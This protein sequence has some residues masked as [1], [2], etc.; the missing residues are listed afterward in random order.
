VGYIEGFL[1]VNRDLWRLVEKQD[2]RLS[3]V[4]RELEYRRGWLTA[5]FRSGVYLANRIQEVYP[6]QGRLLSKYAPLG[7]HALMFHDE[8]LVQRAVNS[9]G[10]KATEIALAE[11]FGAKWEDLR[12][13]LL[14]TA[15]LFRR[16][17]HQLREELD[18]LSRICS[19]YNRLGAFIPH[20]GVLIAS[21]QSIEGSP[22][23][24]AF[25]K[26]VPWLLDVVYNV[27]TG[28]EA[29]G[30]IGVMG[31]PIGS[32]KTTTMYY[33]LRSIANIL[34]HP[35]PDRVASNLILLDPE[36]FL[37]AMDELAS[38]GEKALIT[39]VDN[40]STLFPKYWYTV[41]GEL[42]AFYL[43]LHKSIT[44]IRS[45]STAT[46]FIANAAGEI[47]SFIRNM[48]RV[49]ISG[50]QLSIP[51][52]NV[53]IFTMKEAGVRLTEKEDE[54]VKRERIASVYAY[55]LLKLPKHMYN[56]DLNLK[57]EINR[58]V[59]AEAVKIYKETQEKMMKT[60]K[61][62]QRR[63]K[64]EVEEGGAEI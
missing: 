49:N 19:E 47:A 25:S 64:E 40:S 24:I 52:Y 59:I 7:L 56:Y 14:A 1:S 62:R 31:A 32:G 12:E 11:F 42:R 39:V 17:S 6:A 27:V 30:S 58:R 22:R 10:D 28:S 48:A 23:S 33:V 2:V 34:G 61:T 55:P 50:E 18:R 3:D 29:A 38:R 9:T 5:R 57:K 35:E 51:T 46:I 4:I 20:L 41:G 36:D 15:K 21:D 43:R 44:I 13:C 37:V 16:T 60:T 8:L 26:L 53:T 63:K 54:L 45:L